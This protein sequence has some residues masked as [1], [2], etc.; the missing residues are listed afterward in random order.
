M[1]ARCVRRK[2]FFA[3]DRQHLEESALLALL[4]DGR[5]HEVRFGHARGQIGKD[6]RWERFVAP[7][8]FLSRASDAAELQDE[9]DVAMLS[10]RLRIA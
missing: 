1:R 3:V 4:H 6:R 9:A 7:S 2:A 8:S 10:N 5:P